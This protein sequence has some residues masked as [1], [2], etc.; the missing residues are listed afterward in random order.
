MSAFEQC[1][2]VACPLVFDM[3]PESSNCRQ[4]L[5]ACDACA[6]VKRC[7]DA[8]G[9]DCGLT[10]DLNGDYKYACY[11]IVAQ[12]SAFSCAVKSDP[13]TERIVCRRDADGNQYVF[14]AS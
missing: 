1:R 2:S 5:G 4:L 6:R 11:S 8:R 12:K 7:T 10:P 14:H 13:W 9:V 3:S